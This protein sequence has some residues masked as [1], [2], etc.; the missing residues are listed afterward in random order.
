MAMPSV[1]VGQSQAGRGQCP[2]LR[3]CRTKTGTSAFQRIMSD[4]R[5]RADLDAGSPALPG[6]KAVIERV[7]LCL[8]LD[9]NR[10]NAVR[11]GPSDTHRQG[12]AKLQ[13]FMLLKGVYIIYFTIN[14][15]DLLR[16]EA[17]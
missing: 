15:C 17:S 6:P 12:R 10:Y 1:F 8:I 5:L 4:S 14:H 13:N 7:E 2:G 11:L 16:L 9:R 3:F